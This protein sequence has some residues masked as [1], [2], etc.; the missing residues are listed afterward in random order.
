MRN[1]ELSIV[2]GDCFFAG[3]FYGDSGGGNGFV[4]FGRRWKVWLGKV[5]LLRCVSC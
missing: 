4:V 3:A 1:G 2:V 5:I